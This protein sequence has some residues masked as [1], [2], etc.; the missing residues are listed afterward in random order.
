M[1]RNGG[2]IG[3]YAHISCP[4]QLRGVSLQC[5][6]ERFTR[7]RL[8]HPLTVHPMNTMY[9]QAS[10]TAK[11]QLWQRAGQGKRRVR[12]MRG[13][14]KGNAKEREEGT[15]PW[16]KNTKLPSLVPL[17][18]SPTSPWRQKRRHLLGRRSGSANRRKPTGRALQRSRQAVGPAALETLPYHAA[19]ALYSLI[20]LSQRM[21]TEGFSSLHKPPETIDNPTNGGKANP[22][23]LTEFLSA[24]QDQ[25]YRCASA[26]KIEN[27]C[28]H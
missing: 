18:P 2:N 20:D 16:Q 3:M 11:S 13:A 9:L 5:C 27:R 17:S 22:D 8:R 23:L 28:N 19:C 25:S 10:R 4:K 6:T 14:R 26:T 7:K 15:L 24:S 1:T 21:H 12:M